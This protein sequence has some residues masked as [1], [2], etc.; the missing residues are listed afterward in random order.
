MRL[1]IFIILISITLIFFLF[2]EKVNLPAQNLSFKQETSEIVD[3][4]QNDVD[5]EKVDQEE[6]E[7]QREN[8]GDITEERLDTGVATPVVFKSIPEQLN[9]LILN[10]SFLE[11]GLGD[12]EID[13]LKLM[14]EK[15]LLDK[16]IDSLSGRG[17]LI[18]DS[19]DFDIRGIN[20]S[21]YL[22]KDIA[23]KIA[24]PLFWTEVRGIGS[25]KFES[26]KDFTFLKNFEKNFENNKE[27]QE[28]L[29]ID[30]SKEFSLQLLR[31]TGKK[32]A[33]NVFVLMKNFLKHKELISQAK[34]TLNGQLHL[35]FPA[36]RLFKT[37]LI[38]LLKD[39]NTKNTFRLKGV[40]LLPAVSLRKYSWVTPYLQERSILQNAIPVNINNKKLKLDVEIKNT[41]LYKSL[42][43]ERPKH[44]KEHKM[45][46]Y[47]QVPLTIDGKRLFDYLYRLARLDSDVM[48]PGSEV[49]TSFSFPTE[50]FKQI[51]EA[52]LSVLLKFGVDQALARTI[53]SFSGEGRLKL[54]IDFNE[55]Q[56]F[57]AAIF[58]DYLL[59]YYS[60]SPG[61]KHDFYLALDKDLFEK[62]I[63]SQVDK[64]LQWIE[65]SD[66]VR[67]NVDMSNANQV[68]DIQEI[69]KDNYNHSGIA[70]AGFLDISFK[71][72]KTQFKLQQL[73]RN[74][75]AN[76][77]LNFKSFL[78][79]VT[80]K[81]IVN[82][83]PKDG[84]YVDLDNIRLI[85]DILKQDPDALRLTQYLTGHFT[86]KVSDDF[87][88]PAEAGSLRHVYEYVTNSP[89]PKIRQKRIQQIK[90]YL[91][92]HAQEKLEIPKDLNEILDIVSDERDISEVLKERS[93]F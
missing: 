24:T 13:L 23:N 42:Q 16:A 72:I 37:E 56:V 53:D 68:K 22:L 50:Y 19:R 70:L 44:L 60:E 20:L 78:Q 17:K 76:N 49:Y 66:K 80:G 48:P 65:K 31:L 69:L 62:D 3:I 67:I 51:N 9:Y 5:I 81:G 54:Q 38:S 28:I 34:V 88:K 74:L 40:L 58:L 93:N 15:N 45:Q 25:I 85:M 57:A 32:K 47:L 82:F 30:S 83:F 73:L 11:K 8:T 77:Q 91:S 79:S 2:K 18:I 35:S 26:D 92:S 75:M 10:L 39:F 84:L 87:S 36:I 21:E 64:K 4:R 33:K 59:D 12:Y 1:R 14:L 89:N 86:F 71:D 41:K 7:R 6:V 90:D 55:K 63:K 27:I 43:S 61:I 52:F 46:N 29:K